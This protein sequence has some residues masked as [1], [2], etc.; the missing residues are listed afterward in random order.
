MQRGERLVPRPHPGIV[1]ALAKEGQQFLAIVQVQEDG[2]GAEPVVACRG[3]KLSTDDLDGLGQGFAAKALVRVVG[4]EKG[5]VQME[6]IL[7]FI[8]QSGLQRL[9]GLFRRLHISQEIPVQENKIL[10]N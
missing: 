4:R 9:E 10:T 5:L 7:A 6:G 8:M 3:W 2:A 1:A